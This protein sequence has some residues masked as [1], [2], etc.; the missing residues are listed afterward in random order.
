MT[1]TSHD[2]ALPDAAFQQH[3]A[4]VYRHL[5]RRTGSAE[6]AQELTQEVFADAASALAQLRPSREQILPWLYTVAGWR[7]ADAARRRGREAATEPERAGADAPQLEH[8]T[9][10]Q[11]ALAEAIGRLPLRQREVVTLRLVRGCSF[12]E[13]AVLLDL[14]EDACKKRCRRGLDAVRAHLAADGYGPS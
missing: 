1:D 5:L 12:A 11:G 8:D 10:L 4:R 9:A 6:Q 2:A 13:I 7:L 14:R 3:Y